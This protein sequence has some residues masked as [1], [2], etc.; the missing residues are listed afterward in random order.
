MSKLDKEQLQLTSNPTKWSPS[1][2]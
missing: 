2:L 1:K